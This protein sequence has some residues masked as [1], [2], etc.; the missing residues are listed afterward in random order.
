MIRPQLSLQLHLMRLSPPC[1]W[2]SSNTDH[3]SHQVLPQLRGFAHALSLPGILAPT[4]CSLSFFVKLA[5]SGLQL[6]FTFTSYLGRP[7]IILFCNILCLHTPHTLRGDFVSLLVV[8]LLVLMQVS[9][10]LWPHLS[11]T[12]YPPLLA[13]CWA[14][15]SHC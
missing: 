10:E 1:S 2:Y 3:L 13:H 11:F 15:S 12:L 7:S 5:S 8:C 6:K 9:R 14:Y 4:P